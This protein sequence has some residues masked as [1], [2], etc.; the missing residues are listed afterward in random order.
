[1]NQSDKRQTALISGASS[2]IGL[3]LAKIH[4]A[5]GG[6]LVLVA[7]NVQKLNEL[8]E[9]FSSKFG[10]EVAVIGKDLTQ[11]NA[12]QEVYNEV[13]KQGLQID[14]L[15]NNAGFGDNHAFADADRAKIDDMI[16]LNIRALTDLMLLFLPEMIKRGSGKIL[17]TASV[18]AYMSGPYMATYCATK[19]YVLSLSN[20]IAREVKKSGVTVTAVCP[21]PTDSQFWKVSEMENSKYLKKI[22]L[23]S[24]AYVAKV[25]YKAMLKGKAT[26]IP[27]WWNKAM[28]GAIRLMPRSWTTAIAGF[29]MKG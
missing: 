13:V 26:V 22:K 29:L 17:N 1:M 23:P 27:C 10:V 18:A 15:I 28:V 7:R 19:S 4:A 3:E 21:G 2:G 25:A 16:S 5:A 11:P 9:E 20:A 8:S 6:N 12:A 24:A 14:F